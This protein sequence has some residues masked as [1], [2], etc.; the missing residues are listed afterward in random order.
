ML[1]V[2]VTNTQSTVYPPLSYVESRTNFGAWAILSAPLV[3]GLN[4]TDGPTVD[5]V[6]D[7]LS[8]TVSGHCMLQVRTHAR[9][10]RR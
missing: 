3:I 2:G 8:N 5:S 4:V 10:Q 6:W 9:S 7:I 1:E